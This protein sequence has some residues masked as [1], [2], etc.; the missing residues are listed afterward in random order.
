MGCSHR[1]AR[2][3]SSHS[4]LLPT[5]PGQMR[6]LPLSGVKIRGSGVAFFPD[7]KRIL[8]RGAESGHDAQ[9]YVLEIDRGQ[10]RAFTPE[11]ISLSSELSV[12]PDGKRV[13]SSDRRWKEPDL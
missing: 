7:G 5:G 3:Q 8:I 11:G 12:S 4:V 10:A 13:V 1:R 6:T 2:P 9:L